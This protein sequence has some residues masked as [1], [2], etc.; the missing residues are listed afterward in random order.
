MTKDERPPWQEDLEEAFE[1]VEPEDDDFSDPAHPDHDLSEWS[2][3][4]TPDD[5]SPK[6]WFIRRWA[7]ITVSVLVI[8]GLF[9]PF[10]MRF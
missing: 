7:V 8:V 9:L 1:A 3:Y 5:Y 4:S 6:P 10:L 2:P